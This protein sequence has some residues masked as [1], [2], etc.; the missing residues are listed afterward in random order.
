MRVALYAVLAALLLLSTPADAQERGAFVAFDGKTKEWASVFKRMQEAGMNTAILQYTRTTS[1]Y[2]YDKETDAFIAAA[3]KAGMNYYL[4]LRYHECWDAKP[5]LVSTYVNDSIDLMTTKLPPKLKNA[6]HFK[7]WYMALEVGNDE[8]SVEHTGKLKAIAAKGGKRIAMSVYFNPAKLA[9]AAFAEKIKDT[10]SAYHVVLF[11][12]SVGEHGSAAAKKLTAYY[13]VIDQVYPGELWMIVEAF[14]GKGTATEKAF[15]KQ[16]DKAL[17]LNKGR[18]LFAF[19]F[20]KNLCPKSS[21]AYVAWKARF[22][23][24]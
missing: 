24:R 17:A 7:G 6:R 3:E 20:L 13:E 4:G 8:E 14:R 21:G 19:E 9:P 10:I 1:G 12:D 22:G 23:D 11:Q 2:F 5:D 18:N 15:A 16:V